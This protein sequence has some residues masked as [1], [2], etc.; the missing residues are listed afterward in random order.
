MLR[1]C[2]ICN[3]R[4]MYGHSLSRRGL[5]K[6]K[7]GTGKKTT[8]VTKRRFLPNLH[9]IKAKICGRAKTIYICTKCLKSG[10]IQKII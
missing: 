6:K 5:S 3:K 2:A 9:K 10:K 7:G 4:Q 1:I 8:R